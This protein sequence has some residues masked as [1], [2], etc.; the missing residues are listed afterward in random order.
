MTKSDLDIIHDVDFKIMCE[1]IKIFKE[2]N[3]DYFLIA[4]TLLGAVRHGGFIPWDDDVDIGVPR[5]SYDLFLEKYAKELPA[6]YKVQNFKT[7]TDAKYYV[8]RILD[9]HVE[10]EEIRDESK[11]GAKTYASIDLFPIDGTPN[12]KV[13]R[14][15][16][17]Y[18]ILFLRMLAS[19]SQSSNIDMARKRGA[20]ERLLVNVAKSIP[21]DKFLNRANIYSTIDNILKKN[22]VEGSNYVGSI[23]G[24]YREKELF[25]G[26]YIEKLKYVEFNGVPFLVPYDD[27]KYLRHM[28]GNYMEIPDR[29]EIE[30]KRHYN[31]VRK[32]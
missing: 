10:V 27:D 5:K 9:T 7:N 15:L 17:V 3:L 24:A 30:A 19:F 1:V 4:G 32:V 11:E 12:N 16:F 23:M 28:Y 8:T 29:G 18:R 6:R 22:P 21:F 25:L 26:E 13:K 31:V 20:V 2:H 14:K